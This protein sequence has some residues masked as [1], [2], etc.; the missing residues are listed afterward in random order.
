VT[1][2]PLRWE[3]EHPDLVVGWVAATGVRVEE[4]DPALQ[5][6]LDRVVALR[7]ESAVEEETRAAVRDLLRGHGYKPTGRGKPASEFLARS[8]ARGSFPRINNVVDINNLVSLES[9]LPISVFDHAAALAGAERLEIRRGAAGE[10]FVFNASGQTIDIGGLLGVARPEGSALGNPV[11]DSML[12]KI[13]P[14]TDSVLAVLYG[15]RRV[16]PVPQMQQTVD[17]FGALLLSHAHADQL[18][19]GVLSEDSPRELA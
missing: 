6:E 10:T 11:K 1:A 12:A 9:G 14:A 13:G 19:S 18:A 3:I 5:A 15:S 17:R 4:S 7:A 2:A 16:C 8:A